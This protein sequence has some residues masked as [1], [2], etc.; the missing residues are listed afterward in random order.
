MQET[1]RQ[2]IMLAIA[3]A[4]FAIACLPAILYLRERH[5]LETW[6][7][8]TARIQLTFVEKQQTTSGAMTDSRS[9]RY[10]FRTPDGQV[11]EGVGKVNGL[12]MVGEEVG[13]RYHPRN[14]EKSSIYTIPKT[15][16]YVLGVPW[17]VA[18]LAFA[19]L[20]L[21]DALWSTMSN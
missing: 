14:P 19:G 2:I 13:V 5:T 3:I 7:R 16:W 21:S 9:A 8:G 12:P 15:T 4:A 18:F 10:V 1:E 11:Y 17:T 20:L 6:D